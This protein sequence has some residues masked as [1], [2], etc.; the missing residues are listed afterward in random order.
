MVG[1][2]RETPKPI[3]LFNSFI[4][5][6]SI[7]LFIISTHRDES[8]K[9]I[10]YLNLDYDL[11]IFNSDTLSLLF[12]LLS[13]GYILYAS[14]YSNRNPHYGL[15]FLL[16]L[17]ISAPLIL[18]F[19][20]YFIMQHSNNAWNH[21]KQGL[22]TN[23][24][25]LYKKASF[26]T[27]GALTVFAMMILNAESLKSLNALWSQFFIFLACISLP[28]FVLMHLFYKRFNE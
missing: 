13:F 6:F 5:G 23:T 26:Y 19:G 27:F 17:G 21:V 25:E 9:I 15:L 4:L 22:R 16:F 8:L 2:N 20:L 3:P 11:T 1:F 28:H 14:F 7:L 12:S 10:S 18:A 24:I